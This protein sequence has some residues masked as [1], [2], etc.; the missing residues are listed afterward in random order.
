MWSAELDRYGVPKERDA[1]LWSQCAL[2]SILIRILKPLKIQPHGHIRNV[3]V[4]VS[5]G[6]LCEIITSVLS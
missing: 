4:L 5:I 1:T 2:L 6:F 3:V